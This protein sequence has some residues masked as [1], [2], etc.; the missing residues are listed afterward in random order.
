LLF[1]VNDSSIKMEILANIYCFN[2]QNWVIRFFI[3]KGE[4]K[5]YFISSIH[6]KFLII[7]KNK[8]KKLKLNLSQ[9]KGAEVLTREQLK[10]VTGGSGG[11]GVAGDGCYDFTDCVDGSHCVP[12][13]VWGTYD[14]NGDPNGDG[15]LFMQ[16]S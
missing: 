2:F 10:K 4:T 14:S 1:Q 5:K 8:M 12:T 16:C 11:S 3:E 7:K 9:M 15:G 13:I 6:N